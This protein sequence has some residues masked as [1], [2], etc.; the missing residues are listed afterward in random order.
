MIRVRTTQ[1]AR[2]AID[3]LRGGWTLS[4]YVRRATADWV[5]RGVRGPEK[6]EQ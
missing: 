6:E 4:E 3:S 2:D 5:K 1:Q